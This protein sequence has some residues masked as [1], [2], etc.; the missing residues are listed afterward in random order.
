MNFLLTDQLKKVLRKVDNTVKENGWLLVTGDVGTGKTTL[1]RY[2]SEEWAKEHSYIIMNVTSWRNNGRSRVP[3]LMKRM[4]ESLSPDTLAPIDVELREEKLRGLLLRLQ[5][6]FKRKG[7]N[8]KASEPKRIILV[9]DSAQDIN[10]PTFR[11]LKKLREIHTAPLFPIIMFGN[12]SSIMNTVLSGREVGYRCKHVEL[13]YL[14][15]E[16]ILEFAEQGFGISFETGK[17]GALARE[18][19]C[20]VVHPSPLGVEYF[21]G[22]LDEFS[23]FDGVATVNLIKQASLL[24]LRHRMKRA[25][26]LVSDIT[27]EAKANG[28]SLRTDEVSKI[29]AGK[30]KAS[31]EK[32][33]MI[34]NLTE[35][36]IRNNQ[37]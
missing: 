22:C 7:K 8:D 34:Q 1:R 18:L 5:S 19:F 28:I 15:Y 35:K 20:E 21:K 24:D 11:E 9:V 4:I 23:G 30:T 36:V 12:E 26:V 17:A 6:K 3:V 33:Q 31:D 32:I 29:L 13:D 10:D 14:D 2:I 16:E 27:K 37:G 25:H